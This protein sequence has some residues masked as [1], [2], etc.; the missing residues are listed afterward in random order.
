M[1]NIIDAIKNSNTIREFSIDLCGN[2]LAG[3]QGILKKILDSILKMLE[4]K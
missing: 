1:V 3:N 2:G 4:T